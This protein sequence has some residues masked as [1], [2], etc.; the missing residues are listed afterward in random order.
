MWG[1][2]WDAGCEKNPD[3]GTNYGWAAIQSASCEPSGED[4]AL[5]IIAA[6]AT[7]RPDS[8]RFCDELSQLASSMSFRRD[9]QLLASRR[10]ARLRLSTSRGLA[11]SG[12]SCASSSS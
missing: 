4:V 1:S 6:N 3:P 7:D 2:M 11:R 12:W 5:E 10:I 8:V 9:T